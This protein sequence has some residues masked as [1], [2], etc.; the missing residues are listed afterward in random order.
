MTSP[1]AVEPA[2]DHE[3]MVRIATDTSTVES[4]FTVDPAVLG[5]LG[6]ADPD[7]TQ[8]V[9]HT[10]AFL[11]QQQ[12]VDDFPPLVYLEDVIAAYEDYPEYI[13]SNIEPAG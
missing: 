12:P 8:V 9:H 6:L 1:I 13:R 5:E 3:Y 10:A 7:E 2:G 11:T 4:R